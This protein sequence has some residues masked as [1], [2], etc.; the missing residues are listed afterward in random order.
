MRLN[1]ANSVGIGVLLV[2]ALS[3]APA[4]ARTKHPAAQNANQTYMRIVPADVPNIGP[5]PAA[6][7]PDW[8]ANYFGYVPGRSYGYGP[9]PYVPQFGGAQRLAQGDASCARFRSYDPGS[10]TY[11]GRDGRRHICR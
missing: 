4:S 5:V 1:F 10:G 8:Q 3:V 9:L 7:S 6:T 2:V 11:L